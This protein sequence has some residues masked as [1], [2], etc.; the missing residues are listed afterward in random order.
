M[1]V[2][3]VMVNS[4]PILF[5]GW[6]RQSFELLGNSQWLGPFGVDVGSVGAGLYYSWLNI[7]HIVGALCVPTR[8]GYGW[9]WVNY[10]DGAEWGSYACVG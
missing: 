8:G 9:S 3:I 5:M 10:I 7:I 2:H 4:Q 6:R 1:G